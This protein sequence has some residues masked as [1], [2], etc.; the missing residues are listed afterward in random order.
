MSGFRA[1]SLC[2]ALM[3]AAAAPLLAGCDEPNSA[4]AAIQQP[5][6]DVSIIPVKPHPL[7]M[8]RELPGRVAPTR[9]ADVRPRVSGIVIQRMFRQG[10][11]VKAGHPLYQIDPRPFEGEVRGN[12]APRARAE[13]ISLQASHQAHRIATLTGQHVVSEAEH[14][15]AVATL[16]QAQAD[17]EG[18]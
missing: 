14:E 5:E 12:E 2:V 9:V 18:R 6:P 11:T 7:A 4:S 10:S 17:V 3:L 1:Q 8:L 16:R 15:K 13:A